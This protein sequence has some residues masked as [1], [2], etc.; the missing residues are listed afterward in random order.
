MENEKKSKVS[1][2]SGKGGRKTASASVWLYDKTR[3]PVTGILVNGLEG[4]IYFKDYKN[5]ESKL[6]RP[7]QVTNTLGRF[8]ASTKVFG[9]GKKSQLEA[10]VLALSRSLVEK[11]VDY[12]P[13][14]RKEGLLTRD[15]RM[16]ESKKWGRHK[17]RRGQQF[18]KR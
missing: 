17:A 12:K 14:L 3:S 11:N 4:Q 18:A 15:S 7:F 8:A 5:A 2:V 1:F 13:A 6:L 9:G 10:V 16:V